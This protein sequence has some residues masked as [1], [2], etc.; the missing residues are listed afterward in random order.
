MNNCE[1]FL[2]DSME[3]IFP[4]AK[5]ME[6]IQK[7]HRLD[8]MTI[9]KGE[10]A[11]FQLVYYKEKGNNHFSDGSGFYYEIVN[12]PC[13]ARVREIQL[14]PSDFP[15]YDIADEWYITEK[16]G[17]YPDLLLPHESNFVKFIS[18]QYR[19]LWIDFPKTEDAS[20]GI[21]DITVNIYKENPKE[22]KTEPLKSFH[23]E[24]K[25]LSE[26][27]EKQKLIH[28]E[29]FHTDCIADYYKVPVFS[30]EHW[31]A[32]EKQL[33][34]CGEELGINMILTPVF[35]PPLDTE[36]GGERT[37]VQLV[38]V[39]KY[40]DGK[41]E[42]D[43]SKLKR[44]CEIC[45]KHEI[46]YLEIPHLFTQWGAKAA[47][48]VVVKVNGKDEKLFGWHTS[49]LSEEYQRFIKQFI[50]SLQQFL[51]ACGYDKEHIYFHISDEPNN[52][53]LE[54][55]KAASDSVIHLFDGWNVIDA[56]SE[57]TFYEQG[58]VKHPVAAN[59]HIGPF[60]KNNVK[61][62]WVYY[63]CAQSVD[64]PNRFFAMPSYRNR[65]MGVLMY[66]FNI[67]GF[68]HWGF[69]FYN[70]QCSRRHI[71]PFYVTHAD[72]AFPS[73]DAFLV[74]PGENNEPYSSIR[75]EVQRQALDDLR[76]L[77]LFE[78]RIGR[79]KVLE[80]IK[81]GWEGEPSFENYPHQ[82]DYVKKLRERMTEY[83]S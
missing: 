41:Y 21:Y 54:S 12:V 72:Y 2:I 8:K 67:E 35:T 53:N 27:L 9:Y 10:R 25:I 3:K 26:K 39:T 64:V 71:N 57:Y 56:L 62:V 80:I 75:A 52:D 23:F 44:W 38:D 20:E 18:G 34:I 61:N 66:I 69:N 32:I 51:L 50:P 15:C 42:F 47:P 81:E 40:E 11:A 6:C 46:E 74:Y 31:D 45:K 65:I 4:D 55:Y 59:N 79:E 37:T 60:L 36:I 68:L 29:W 14:V 19:S 7:K 22:T 63:C 82:D 43:F 49:A 48:K 5:D 16:P 78:K 13:K 28:T 73:G 33:A 76:A 58:I 77:T 30:E 24:L 17:L 1:F 70:S 83:M